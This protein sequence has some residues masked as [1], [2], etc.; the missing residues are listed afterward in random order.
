MKLFNKFSFRLYF[1]SDIDHILNI[2][3]EAG[4]VNFFPP[5]LLYGGTE[6]EKFEFVHHHDFGDLDHDFVEGD[7][8]ETGFLFSIFA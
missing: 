8:V 1:G 4:L 7:V 5:H 2:N 3:I 6:E